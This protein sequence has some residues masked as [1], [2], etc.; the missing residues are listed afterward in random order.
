MPAFILKVRD[1]TAYTE[2]T[3]EIVNGNSDYTVMFDFDAEWDGAENLTAHIRYL[4]DGLPV[5][6][7]IPIADGA[8]NL[9][10]VY[11]TDA[12][13]IGVS[14]GSIRTSTPA[15]V[16]CLPCAADAA[17]EQQSVP[18][19]D[20]FCELMQILNRKLS[21]IEAGTHEALETYTH[22]ELA[23]YT[24]EQLEMLPVNL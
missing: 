3:P 24:H 8:C 14:G 10:A 12:V 16:P 13:Q 6:D 19:P 5:H 23:Q 17:G 4:R 20:V 22:A 9:P 18:P 11:G 7:E 15:A 2:G 1:K 21:P